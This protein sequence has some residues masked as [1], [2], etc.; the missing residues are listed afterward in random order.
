MRVREAN[1]TDIP[2]MM[3]LE[4]ESPNSANWSHEHYKNLFRTTT[5]ELSKYFV[6]VV[7]DPSESKDAT[8]SAPTPPVVAYLAAQ[9]VDRE[10]EL[11]YIV[12][13]KKSRRRGLATLLL[14]RLV[15]NARSGN[16]GAVFLEV[17][18]SNQ[19]ARDL[20]RKMG[21]KETGVRKGYYPDTG[22]DALN[23]YLRLS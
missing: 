2:A 10:W 9:C 8:A 7:E 4:N 15:E 14:S 1:Y 11:H 16:A 13:A 22:E 5:P 20:Y 3:E 21:F 19:A 23:C 18:E 6:L 17:R 12:V